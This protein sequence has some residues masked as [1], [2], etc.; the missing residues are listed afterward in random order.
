[1]SALAAS[2]QPPALSALLGPVKY[3]KLLEDRDVLTH[4]SVDDQGGG[5]SKYSFYGAMQVRNSLVQ[6]RQIMTDYPVYARMVPYVDKVEYQPASRTWNLQGGIFHWK[7]NSNVFFEERGPAWVH[8]RIVGGHFTG[9]Q[10]DLIFESLGE[11]GTTVY[12]DGNLLGTKWP[13][14]FIIERG[15]E[16]VMSFTGKKMRDFIESQKRLEPAGK[17]EPKN[18]E[19]PRPRSHL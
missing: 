2:P 10:G 3:Q 8:Y 17:G 18:E 19:I 7:L 16:I 4:A 13:P 1:V 6:T 14:R 11:K 12:F 9:L 15:A 5:L